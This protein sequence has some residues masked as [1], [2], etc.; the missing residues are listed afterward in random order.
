MVPPSVMPLPIGR[1]AGCRLSIFWPVFVLA[2]SRA[3]YLSPLAAV[4]MGQSIILSPSWIPRLNSF[5]VLSY[6]LYGLLFCC[7]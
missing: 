5:G 6:I 4:S 7:C 2:R 3:V 1:S